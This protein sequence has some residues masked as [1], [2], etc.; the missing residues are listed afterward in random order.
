MPITN[1]KAFDPVRAAAEKDCTRVAKAAKAAA[2][3][4]DK[5]LEGGGIVAP[6]TAVSPEELTDHLMLHKVEVSSTCTARKCH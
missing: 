4:G 1:R 6:H 2:S 3:K 5:C